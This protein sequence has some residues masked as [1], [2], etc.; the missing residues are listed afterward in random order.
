M[1]STIRDE[2]KILKLFKDV[3]DNND[4]N[5]SDWVKLKQQ[6]ESFLMETNKLRKMKAFVCGRYGKSYKKHA[7]Y[8][9]KN[10]DQIEAYIKYLQRLHMLIT[11]QQ[12]RILILSKTLQK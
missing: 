12:I 9:R 6:K 5:V 8:L 10:P 1:K 11:R 2:G 7:D 3:F 4:L